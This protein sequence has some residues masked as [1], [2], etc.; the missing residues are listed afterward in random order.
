MSTAFGLEPFCLVSK[1]SFDR[2]GHGTRLSVSVERN[3][4]KAER[5]RSVISARFLHDPQFEVLV[6]GISAPLERHEGLLN[7]ETLTLKDG[8]TVDAF[9]IDAT[10]TARR[11]QPHGVAFWVGGRLVGETGWIVGNSTLLDGRLQAAKRYT[12]IIKSDDLF[13]EV[14]SD[15]TGFR[16]SAVIKELYEAVTDYVG[17]MIRKVMSEYV[18]ETKE[19]VLRE[20]RTEIESLQ[21]LGKLEVAEF[22][23]ALVTVDPGMDEGILS[24]AVADRDQSREIQEWQGTSRKALSALRRRC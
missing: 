12:A 13:D 24:A 23:N 14:L 15:W 22:V 7:R 17:K 11:M 21:P 5:I 18:V 8:T 19:A 10:K 1:D 4:P 9:F 16:E 3:L 6:N 20:H 2:E